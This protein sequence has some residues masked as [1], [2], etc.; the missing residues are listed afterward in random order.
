MGA[1]GKNSIALGMDCY[2]PHAFEMALGSHAD[3][4]VSHI[5]LFGVTDG[6]ASTILY[7]NNDSL[8]TID[9]PS[10]ISSNS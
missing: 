2:A 9:I 3:G 6:V 7:A 5:P 4:K 1:M 10:G 8:N